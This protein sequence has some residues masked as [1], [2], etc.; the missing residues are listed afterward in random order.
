MLPAVLQAEAYLILLNYICIGSRNMLNH[1]ITENAGTASHWEFEW[2]TNVPLTDGTEVLRV[3]PGISL[4]LN[5]DC[6]ITVAESV[7]L[8]KKI[9]RAPPFCM[10]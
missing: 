4:G 9:P 6:R 8:R 10:E 1:T 5:S 3:T 7:A 2:D